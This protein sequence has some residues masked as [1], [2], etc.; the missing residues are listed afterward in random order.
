MQGTEG[1]LG[2]ERKTARRGEDPGAPLTH[3]SARP[4]GVTTARWTRGALYSLTA[5]RSRAW[6]WGGVGSHLKD[7]S[8][9][10]RDSHHVPTASPFSPTRPLQSSWSPE[11][12]EPRKKAGEARRRLLVWVILEM[13]KQEKLKSTTAMSV[14]SRFT[15][16]VLMVLI[17]RRRRQPAAWLE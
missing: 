11:A 5:G 16:L 13:Q 17:R 14:M 2:P 6:W 12:P 3:H 7:P 4:A 9:R 1:A 15:C 8:M 10:A